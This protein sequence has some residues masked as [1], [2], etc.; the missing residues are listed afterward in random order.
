MGTALV[1][2]WLREPRWAALA[3]SFLMVVLVQGI[4]SSFSVFLLPLSVE[5]GGLRSAAAAAFSVHNLAVGLVA[6]VVDRLME[7]FGERLVLAVG[8]VVLG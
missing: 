8:A 5:L 3:T 7:R 1:P 6:T 4:S 2:G